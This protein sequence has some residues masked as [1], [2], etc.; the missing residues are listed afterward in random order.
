MVPYQGPFGDNRSAFETDRARA[1]RGR[2]TSQA[3]SAP[4]RIGR[5]SPRLAGIVGMVACLACGAGSDPGEETGYHETGDLSALQA[6]GALR[7]LTPPLD[8]STLP[9]R[10]YSL[11]DEVH[12]AY[13]ERNRRR[14]RMSGQVRVRVRYKRHKTPWFDYLLVSEEE[15]ARLL[16]GTGWRLEKTFHGDEGQYCGVIGK[17]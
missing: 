10:G 9:R 2:A 17:S 6:Q 7:I 1:R 5:L 4:E 15:M 14:G 11:D 3:I 16:D 8:P 12:L 13:H